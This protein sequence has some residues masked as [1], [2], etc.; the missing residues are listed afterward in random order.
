MVFSLIYQAVED[1]DKINQLMKWM[2]TDIISAANMISYTM[3]QCR[4]IHT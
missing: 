1:L 4:G 2:E 3:I